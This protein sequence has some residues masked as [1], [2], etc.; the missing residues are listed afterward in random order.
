MAY[1]A[2]TAAAASRASRGPRSQGKYV[3]TLTEDEIDF[4]KNRSG[5]PKTN[6]YN[7]TTY[8][9]EADGS[10]IPETQLAKSAIDDYRAEKRAAEKAEKKASKAAS[11]A[12]KSARKSEKKATNTS[13]RF[14]RF[15]TRKSEKPT[16]TSV[17]GQKRRRTHRQRHTLR[18]RTLR[19]R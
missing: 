15:F 4:I 1:S 17:G 13:S 19:R 16:S 2:A 14:K 5:V 3:Y 10:F 18:R 11:V 8:R 7:L 6:R 12:A 9:F